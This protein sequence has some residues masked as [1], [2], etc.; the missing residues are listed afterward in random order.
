MIVATSYPDLLICYN[1]IIS[2]ALSLLQPNR[3]AC[4][5]VGDIR[6]PKG[7][8][9]NFVSDTIAVFGHAGAQLYNEAILITA[10]GSLP[11]RV[12]KMFGAGRK[13]GKTHQNVLVFVKGDWREATRACGEL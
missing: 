10:I 13:L 4:F 7:P 9:R 2:K 6:S 8:Y 11:I 3:F 1:E 12:G 5:V